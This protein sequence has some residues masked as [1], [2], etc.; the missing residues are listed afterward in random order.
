MRQRN[1]KLVIEYKGTDF[2]GWQI[3][4][5]QRTVQEEITDAIRKVTGLEVNLTGAGRT[6]AGVH[7]LGQV[8]N[9]VV[10]HSLPPERYK[11]ALNFYLSHDIMIKESGE[12]DPGFHARR[13]AVTKR[14]RYLISNER[15]ALY[16]ELRWEHPADLDLA[17]L[18]SAAQAILGEHDFAPFCVLSSRKENNVCRIESA[19]WHRLGTLLIFEIRGNRFLHGMVRSIVGGMV[20]VASRVRD[21]NSQNLTLEEFRD[22]VEFSPERRVPFTAPPQGLY[23]VSVQYR[24]G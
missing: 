18:R 13:D 24:K 22:I 17:L 16:R 7:A 12:A 4:A 20:N 23:L 10:D 2:A 15:S 3:Q 5:A 8:A 14:Y 21:N 6:D 1:I 19:R 9:F 11:D